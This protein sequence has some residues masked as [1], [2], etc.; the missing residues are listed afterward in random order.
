LKLLNALEELDVSGG[1]GL[2]A[3]PQ[4]SRAVSL[5]EAGRAEVIVVAFFDRLVR[6]L[7]AQRELLARDERRALIRAVVE[8]AVVSPG[9]G[10]DRI[11]IEARGRNRPDDPRPGANVRSSSSPATV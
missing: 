2:D 1:A 7:A 5:V 3:R 6:S 8:R 10:R 9:H 11:S 4:L